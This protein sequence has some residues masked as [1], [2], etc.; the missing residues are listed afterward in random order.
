MGSAGGIV[1]QERALGEWQMPT[2][3]L[4]Q[5]IR[6]EL[7]NIKIITLEG[8]SMADTLGPGDKVELIRGRLVDKMSKNHPHVDTTSRIVRYL[9][10]ILADNWFLTPEGPIALA[11]SVGHHQF[12]V[13]ADRS[14]RP[15]VAHAERV[16][17]SAARVLLLLA[18]EGPNLIALHRLARQVHQRLRLVEV[19]GHTHVFK[20]LGHSVD[21]H[22][23]DPSD[24]PH[25]HAFD[26]Q[27]NDLRAL[28]DGESVHVGLLAV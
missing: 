15:H 10:R 2:D 18:A 23:G 20:Q 11:D 27:T 26:Q 25:R 16:D 5:E 12:G 28:F 19:A 21:R 24:R 13:G 3:W 4:R 8:D 9:S 7:S 6:G 22:P 17:F 14:P 1:D